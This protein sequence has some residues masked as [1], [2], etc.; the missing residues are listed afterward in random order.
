M[1]RVTCDKCKT[2]RPEPP[3]GGKPW[4]TVSVSTEKWRT[5]IFVTDLCPVCTEKL[6]A[7]LATDQ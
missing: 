6:R 2:E 4:V 1:V 5:N 3:K 7:F